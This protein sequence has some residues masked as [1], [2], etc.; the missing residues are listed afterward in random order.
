ML[1]LRRVR[2]CK[3]VCEKALVRLAPTSSG[4]LSIWQSHCCCC[5]GFSQNSAGSSPFSFCYKDTI[6]HLATNWWNMFTH[7]SCWV[8]LYWI[9][10]LM[11][12]E[13]TALYS[14]SVGSHLTETNIMYEAMGLHPLHLALPLPFFTF[15]SSTQSVAALAAEMLH[16]YQTGKSFCCQCCHR[17]CGHVWLIL[18]DDG[19]MLLSLQ[20]LIGET[21]ACGRSLAKIK[22]K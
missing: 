21:Q 4:I 13:E 16:I 8:F 9:I 7:V 15:L 1:F 17:L 5:C 20:C 14:F 12:K 6:K 10:S 11:D 22:H 18:F 3:D 2:L 19:V